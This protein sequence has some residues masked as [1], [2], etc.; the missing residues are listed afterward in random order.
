MLFVRKRYCVVSTHLVQALQISAGFAHTVLVN[1]E[2][3][4]DWLR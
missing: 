1:Q 3:V 2:F 4:E